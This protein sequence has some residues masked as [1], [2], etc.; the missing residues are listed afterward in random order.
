MPRFAIIQVHAYL[1]T[2]RRSRMSALD[3]EPQFERARPTTKNGDDIM[4][5]WFLPFLSFF[6]SFFSF[7]LFFLDFNV[8]PDL[9]TSR[10][11]NT[12][13]RGRRSLSRFGCVCVCGGGG[14][15]I[16]RGDRRITKERM[17]EDR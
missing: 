2:V 6:F 14:R 16:A 17:I 15:E 3:Y 13:E 8:N 5:R 10:A 7:S 1:S 4:H 9:E 11:L 12:C